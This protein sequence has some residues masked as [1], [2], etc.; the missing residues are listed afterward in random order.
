MYACVYARDLYA[1]ICVRDYMHMC[2]CASFARECASIT[3]VVY[4]VN[5][6][7]Y[8]DL[9]IYLDKTGSGG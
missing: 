6:K 7:I 3:R 9:K 8:K 1:P 4:G 5:R 2:T